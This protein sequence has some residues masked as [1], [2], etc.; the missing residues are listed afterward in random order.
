MCQYGL[1]LEKGEGVARQTSAPFEGSLM[2]EGK[3][4]GWGNICSGRWSEIDWQK[5]WFGYDILD[6][7]PLV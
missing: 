5:V 2:T 6:F 7:F 4:E 3:K 1:G